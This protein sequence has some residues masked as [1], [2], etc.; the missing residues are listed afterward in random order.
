MWLLG[1]ADQ[2]AEQNREALKLG[3]EVEHALSRG[4]ALFFAAAHA[5]FRHEWGEL[6]ALAGELVAFAEEQELTFWLT[7]ALILRGE[8]SS[9]QEIRRPASER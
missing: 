9:G 3:R 5:H 8:C 4:H 1:F 7:A 6:R 2:A